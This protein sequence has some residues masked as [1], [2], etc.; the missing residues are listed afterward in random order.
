[1]TRLLK[2]LEITQLLLQMHEMVEFL[3]AENKTKFTF[4]LS[5]LAVLF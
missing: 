2:S 4:A 5:F 1:M 3:I